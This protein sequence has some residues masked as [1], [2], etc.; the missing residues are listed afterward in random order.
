M[1]TPS[2]RTPVRIARGSYSNLNSSLSDLQDGEI[3]YAEDQNRLYIKEG[4]SLVVLTYTAANPV[5]TGNATFDTNTLYVDGTNN[6]VGI[7][8]A[9][10]NSWSSSANNLVVSDTAGNGGITIVNGTSGIGS[11]FFADGTSTNSRGRLRYQHSNDSLTLSTAETT[12]LTL[13]SSQ[14]A[15]F[16]GTVTSNGI[17][18]YLLPT[19]ANG[20]QLGYDDSTKSLRFYANSSSGSNSKIQ[21]HFNQSGTASITF[22]QS[23]HATFTGQVNVGN[24]LHID[25]TYP[26][27]EL[28]DTDSNSD[29]QI[30]NANG[31]F[32]IR[33]ITNNSNR[34]TITSAGAAEF[35]SGTI[36]D[37]KGNLRSIPKNAKSSAYVAVATDAGKAIYISSGGVTLNNS[38]FSAGDAVTIINDS[39]SNQTITQGSGVTMYH[40]S[41]G[42]T[43]NRTLAGR[44]MC[45]VWF[46]SASKAY[47]GG[48]GLT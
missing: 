2:T 11:I 20:G 8:T 12:A 45:T 27:I 22:D 1:P 3:I 19:M 21:F 34:F 5:F 6:L 10:P 13:D 31:E 48:S 41:T 4:G 39:G 33:D 36:S 15:T 23:S 24:E 25:G 40:T 14:N 46:E 26:L 47:I 43:G 29:W 18:Q 38:V 16:A 37:S 9:S 30:R 42:L 28:N 7:G 32:A 44:G 17:T 35:P